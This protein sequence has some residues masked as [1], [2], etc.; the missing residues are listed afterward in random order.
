[1]NDDDGMPWY[2]GLSDW[3]CVTSADTTSPLRAPDED[4]PVPPPRSI[5]DIGAP[6]ETRVFAQYKNMVF[7]E[8]TGHFTCPVANCL[9]QT[10]RRGD[11]MAHIEHGEP[12]LFTARPVY[13]CDSPGCTRAFTQS[14]QLR[15]HK[16][17]CVFKLV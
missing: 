3:D 10:R 2:A 11:M 12:H 6:T 14:R 16:K 7:R 8:V 4:L 15:A 13:S 9:H 1:M 17:D 5:T